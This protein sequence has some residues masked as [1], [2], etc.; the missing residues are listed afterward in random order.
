M[1]DVLK[2]SDCVTQSLRRK[3]STSATKAALTLTKPMKRFAQLE[4]IKFRP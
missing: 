2:E 1:N 3:L 4:L